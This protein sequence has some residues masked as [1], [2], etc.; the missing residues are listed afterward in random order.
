MSFCI[1]PSI[2]SRVLSPGHSMLLS[3]F[4][5]QSMTYVPDDRSVMSYLRGSQRAL[6]PV[7]IETFAVAVNETKKLL[8]AVPPSSRLF[9]DVLE[10]EE[11]LV[12]R[13]QSEGITVPGNGK[14]LIPF[15]QKAAA[16]AARFWVNSRHDL[17]AEYPLLNAFQLWDGMCVTLPSAEFVQSALDLA[18]SAEEADKSSAAG[19]GHAQPTLE[20]LISA[21][22]TDGSPCSLGKFVLYKPAMRLTSVCLEH[23]GAREACA[24]T[25]RLSS[26]QAAGRGQSNEAVTA[27][28]RY[29]LFRL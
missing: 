12:S 10:F 2:M 21:L 9:D 27:R 1:S 19:S 11:Y 4:C 25:P 7:F 18:R 20:S 17:S 15:E 13:L 16:E 14:R 6:F 8:F 29:D 26:R 22:P 23:S 28:A 5:L 3:V 24:A